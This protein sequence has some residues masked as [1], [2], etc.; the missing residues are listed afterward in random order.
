[1]TKLNFVISLRMDFRSQSG[2]IKGIWRRG[3]TET[4]KY[5]IREAEVHRLHP[6]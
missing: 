6:H 4:E 2:L 1:M 5:N 3:R